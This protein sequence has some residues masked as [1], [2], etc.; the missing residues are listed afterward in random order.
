MLLCGCWKEIISTFRTADKQRKEILQSI[1]V[2][3]YSAAWAE[4][5]KRAILH[6]H[7]QYSLFHQDPTRLSLY[8]VSR[9]GRGGGKASIADLLFRKSTHERRF[10]VA[11]SRRLR[12]HYPAASNAS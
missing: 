5:F 6:S 10:I 2:C 11:K 7:T 4:T 3:G 1:S 12:I 9:G 8:F